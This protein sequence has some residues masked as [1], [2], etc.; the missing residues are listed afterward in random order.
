M[1]PQAFG[2]ALGAAWF[3]I[4]MALLELFA[5]AIRRTMST[6]VHPSTLF[7]LGI[8]PPIGA[9][10]FV[11]GLFVP[12]HWM[13]EPT[14]AAEGIN[15][16]VATLPWWRLAFSSGPS[17]GRCGRFCLLAGSSG[18]GCARGSGSPSTEYRFPYW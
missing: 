17:P 12:A 13:L 6:D 3:L 2:L 18:G 4:A 5:I 14:Q 7:A 8:A 9:L 15:L 1:H 16:T 10:A 11:V